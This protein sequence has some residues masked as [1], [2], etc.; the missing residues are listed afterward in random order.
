MKHKRVTNK[1]MKQMLNE[2]GV[3]IDEKKEDEDQLLLEQKKMSVSDDKQL[4]NIDSQ[5]K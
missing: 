2:I 4:L 5:D 1:R 3:D